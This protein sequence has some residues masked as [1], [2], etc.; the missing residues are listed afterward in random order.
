MGIPPQIEQD[1]GEEL[2]SS[3][4]LHPRSRLPVAIEYYTGVLWI[5]S[6]N[7]AVQALVKESRQT[8]MPTEEAGSN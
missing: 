3:V 4:Y 7:G 8:T 1:L 6:G 5:I 2:S